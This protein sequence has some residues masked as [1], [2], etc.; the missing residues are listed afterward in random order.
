[1]TYRDPSLWYDSWKRFWKNKLNIE[2]STIHRHPKDEV[3]KMIGAFRYDWLSYY[4]PSCN[5]VG[6]A[7]FS[8]SNQC[9][10]M[11]DKESMINAFNSHYSAAKSY[12][13]RR[14][15]DFLQ[16]NVGRNQIY[17]RSLIS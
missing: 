14:K 16:I 11:L 2:I 13:A 8:D 5:S 4:F 15:D 9:E 10:F 17:R 1:M 6:N 12:F 3:I 7:D